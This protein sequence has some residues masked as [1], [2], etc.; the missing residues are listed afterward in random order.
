MSVL[1]KKWIIKSSSGAKPILDILLENRGLLSAEEKEKFLRADKK[2]NFHDPFKMNGMQKAVERIDE[3]VKTNEKIMIFGDYDVDGIASAAILFYVL[4]KIEAQSSIRLPHREKDGYG[5]SKKF[6]DEFEKLDVGLVITVDCGISCADEIS[7]AKQKGIDVIITD[8]HQIP[9]KFPN[10]AHTILH[11]KLKDSTYPFAELTGAGVALKVAQAILLHNFSEEEATEEVEKLTELAALGTIAD[12]GILH[13]ENR[14]IVKEGLKSIQNTK[15][16]GIQI[17][18]NL[19]GVGATDEISTHTVGFQLAPR[20]NA[21]GRIGDPYSALK[22]LISTDNESLY[23]YG[24]ELDELNQRRQ[25]MTMESFDEVY[26]VF[27]DRR[28]NG[29]TPYI[30]IAENENW[31]VGILGLSAARI[32]ESFGRPAVVMQDL[33]TTLVGSARSIEAFNVLEAIA[34][35]KDHLINFGGHKE[36]AGFTVKKENLNKFKEILTKYAEEKLRDIDLRPTLEIECE[37]KKEDLSERF[38]EEMQRLKPFGVRNPRPLFVLKNVKPMF[39]EGVGR[40]R[41]HIKFDAIIDDKTMPAIGFRLG[42]HID[43]IRN[44]KEIELAC[45]IDFNVWNGNRKLQLEIVDFR[46]N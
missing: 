12:L 23:Q 15:W 45:Y 44:Y 28:K 1:G 14:L 3:A 33:G 46:K 4:N 36:A 10:D 22:L 20:I 11:P 24:K 26:K 19:A 9:E 13:G 2:D 21:A 17:L 7:Y 5:L 29:D 43:S 38:V 16:P 34:Q 18:K 6:I 25:K 42:A 35:A 8:H 37:I 27:D 40:S 32:A 41:D 31:H 30:L 39:V